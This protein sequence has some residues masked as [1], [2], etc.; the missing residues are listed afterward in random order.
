MKEQLS[1]VSVQ[2][3][4]TGHSIQNPKSK[5]QDGNHL[6]NSRKIFVETE[7]GLRVPFREI[8]L[9]PSKAFDGTVEANQPV[10]VYDTSGPWTDPEQ[11]LDVRDGLPAHRLDWILARGD[12]E[13]V[14]GHGDTATRGR[15]ERETRRRGDTATRGESE[16]GRQESEPG[17]IATGA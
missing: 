10:R 11:H 17:A 14:S 9:A 13:E 7:H 16:S 4:Q 12:V 15:G 5:I 2:E 6:P 1:V 3:S 8:S